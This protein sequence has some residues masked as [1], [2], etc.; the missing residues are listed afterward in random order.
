MVPG[1][2]TITYTSPDDFIELKHSIT[3]RRALAFGAVLAGEFLVKTPMS[4]LYS[5]DDLL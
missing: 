3:N 5:M 4:G 2:H 1:I